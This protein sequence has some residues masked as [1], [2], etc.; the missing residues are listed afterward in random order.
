MLF[1]EVKATKA[2]TVDLINLDLGDAATP[3]GIHWVGETGSQSWD[4]LSQVSTLVPVRNDQ[5]GDIHPAVKTG[6]EGLF[7]HCCIKKKKEKNVFQEFVSITNIMECGGGKYSKVLLLGRM[8]EGR[9]NYIYSVKCT[10][11]YFNSDHG[12]TNSSF[13]FKTSRQEET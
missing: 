4:L 13:N 8:V 10:C 11:Y 12:H 7:Y 5:L 6:N 3:Q 9:L 1:A 2:A